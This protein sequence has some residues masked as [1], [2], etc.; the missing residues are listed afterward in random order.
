MTCASSRRRLGATACI[1]GDEADARG[2]LPDGAEDRARAK[3]R[4]KAA[5]KAQKEARRESRKSK[6][7]KH[8]KKKACKGHKKV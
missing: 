2:R 1:A 4:K 7:K 3:E 8:V 6:V 5:A